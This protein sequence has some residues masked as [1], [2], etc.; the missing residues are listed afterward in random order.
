[1][2]QIKNIVKLAGEYRHAGEYRSAAQV[3]RTDKNGKN[4][5]KTISY[6][7]PFIDSARFMGSS[8]SN[9]VNNLAEGIHKIKCK[10]EHHN[11][12]CETWN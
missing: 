11:K 12:N 10:N 7:L 9:L 5:T 1:M 8:L 3:T 4:P 2:P 6:R